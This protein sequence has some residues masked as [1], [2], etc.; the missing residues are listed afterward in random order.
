MT[1]AWTIW[2]SLSPGILLNKNIIS[3]IHQ[4]TLLKVRRDNKQ[5]TKSQ[6]DDEKAVGDPARM[7]PMQSVDDA[8]MVTLLPRTGEDNVD[9]NMYDSNNNNGN[10]GSS[11]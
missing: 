10:K 7:M 3:V 2:L 11:K 5:V 4:T 8:R 9:D 1:S 6:N